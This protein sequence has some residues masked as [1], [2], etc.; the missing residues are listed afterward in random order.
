MGHYIFS[1]TVA[2]TWIQ[3]SED[4]SPKPIALAEMFALPP[5]SACAARSAKGGDVRH[6]DRTSVP[7]INH[8]Y[9]FG[10]VQSGFSFSQRH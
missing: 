9:M 8:T 10:R 5:Q 4:A 7:G 6:G 1:E 2:G 3:P